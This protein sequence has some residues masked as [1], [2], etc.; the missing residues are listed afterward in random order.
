[1]L[2]PPYSRQQLNW[3]HFGVSHSGDW[4]LTLRPYYAQLFSNLCADIMFN[5]HTGWRISSDGR[6]WYA[7]FS[8]LDTEERESINEFVEKYQQFVILDLNDNISPYYSDE[9]D[10]C[11][12]L[13]FNM[14]QTDSGDLMRTEDGINVY[15]AKYE[16][17]PDAIDTLGQDMNEAINWL[18]IAST[19]DRFIPRCLTYIPAEPDKLFHLPRELA[20]NLMRR[21]PAEDAHRLGHLIEARLT[22]SKIPL[23]NATL[24]EKLAE[25]QRIT[26]EQAIDL[27][28]SVA[29]RAVYVID[30]LYQSGVTMWTFAK[31]LKSIGARWV[32]G[33][34]AVKSLR[35]TD[36]V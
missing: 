6:H 35:D 14:F 17:S 32:F 5:S 8:E 28:A 13:N 27:S 29:G 18:P 4:S 3:H 26:T 24:D 15:R 11:M 25:W 30:D 34:V 23:K 33:L 9:L 36:N 31:Y 1:M 19:L 10:A 12:C 16:R 22:T 7:Y 2:R 21:T 20:Y